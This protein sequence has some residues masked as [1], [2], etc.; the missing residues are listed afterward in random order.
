MKLP[1]KVEEKEPGINTIFADMLIWG[2][3]EKE[4]K[5]TK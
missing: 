3:D 4:F 5:S 1:I 2:K